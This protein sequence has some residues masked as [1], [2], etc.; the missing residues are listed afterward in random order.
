MVVA[1]LLRSLCRLGGRTG[2][3]LPSACMPP[4]CQWESVLRI[5]RNLC[6]KHGLEV[7]LQPGQQLGV[8]VGDCYIRSG[9]QLTTRPPPFDITGLRAATGWSWIFPDVPV[10]TS[11][12]LMSLSE[13]FSSSVRVVLEQMGGRAT[14]TNVPRPA[15]APRA[16]RYQSIGNDSSWLRTRKS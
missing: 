14:Y 3:T 13:R 5:R 4:H 9:H 10:V 6:S 1:P 11:F 16:T 2:E 15:L 12:R 8:P 7:G